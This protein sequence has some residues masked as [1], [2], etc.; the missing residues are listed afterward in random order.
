MFNEPNFNKV[1]LAYKLDLFKLNCILDDGIYE[2]SEAL[3]TGHKVSKPIR[4]KVQLKQELRRAKL[5]K[6][7][8]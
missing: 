3:L 7:D 5:W 4:D 2:L 8:S 6:H 1:R